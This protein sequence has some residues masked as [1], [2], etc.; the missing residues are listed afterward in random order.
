MCGQREPVLEGPERRRECPRSWELSQWRVRRREA[1]ALVR[2]LNTLLIAGQPCA[3]PSPL[4]FSRTVRPSLP[5]GGQLCGET[6]LPLLLRVY[7]LP[8]VP[9]G[10]HLR[11]RGHPSNSA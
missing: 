8:L 10:L 1:L 3:D 7:S 9:D 2:P 4:P 11:L 5:L 6:E